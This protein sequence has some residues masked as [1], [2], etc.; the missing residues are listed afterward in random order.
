MLQAPFVKKKKIYCSTLALLQHTLRTNKPLFRSLLSVAS[1]M[2]A[3]QQQ[4]KS[5]VVAG[6]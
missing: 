5:F 3:H 6:M 4:L 2:Q 1:V